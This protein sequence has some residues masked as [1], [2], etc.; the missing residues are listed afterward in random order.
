MKKLLKISFFILGT[1]LILVLLLLAIMQTPWFKDFA[2]KQIE[3]ITNEQLN[4][5]LSIGKIDGN[6]LGSLRVTDIEIRQGNSRFIYCDK[7][8]FDYD[9]TGIISNSIIINSVLIDSLSINIVQL[10]DTL[11]NFNDLIKT[12]KD[13]D[14]SASEKFNWKIDVENFNVLNSN[15]TFTVLDTSTLIPK[16][17]D[18]V[19][20]FAE[21]LIKPESTELKINNLGFITKNPG[22]QLENLFIDAKLTDTELCIPSFIIRTKANEININGRYFLGT[23]Q[24]SYLKLITQPI[25][26]NEFAEFLPSLKLYGNPI[27][28]ISGK[29][30]NNSADID[31]SIV[32]KK[33]KINLISN[34]NNLDILPNYN[35]EIEIIKIDVGYWL[36][37]SSLMTDLNAQLNING[38]GTSIE[39]FNAKADLIVYN[40]ELLGRNL[41]SLKISSLI[42]E[43]YIKNELSIKSEFG[44]LSGIVNLKDFNTAQQFDVKS[45]VNNLNIAPLLLDSSLVSN[46]NFSLSAV[47]N[48]FNTNKMNGNFSFVMDSSKFNNYEI[49]SIEAFITI[50]E[51]VYQI[52]KFNFDNNALALILKGKFSPVKSN[53]ILF[54]IV[55][56]D[57]EKL[58]QLSNL[59]NV[60]IDGG[61]NGQILGKSDSLTAK[62]NY[63]FSN[64]TLSTNSASNFYGEIN[65]I[66][67]SDSI[68][69]NLTSKI[70]N[71]NISETNISEIEMQGEYSNDRIKSGLSIMLDENTFA[72]INSSVKID[73]NINIIIPNLK[74]ALS[75][76]V[77]SNLN[78]SIKI[79]IGDDYY[80]VENFSLSNGNQRLAVSGEIT[81]DSNNL[82]LTIDSLKIAQFLTMFD[83]ENKSSATVNA[84]IKIDGTNELPIANGTITLNDLNYD[85]YFIGDVKTLFFLKDEKLNWDFKLT[86]KG[87]KIISE[88]YIPLIFNIDSSQSIIPGDKQFMANLKIDSLSLK[89]FA[90][91]IEQ[92]DEVEGTV[93]SNLSL[94]NTLNKIEG[95][96]Y[97]LIEDANLISETFGLRYDKVNL[98]IE[99]DSQK[100]F[101]KQIEFVNDDG[102]LNINGVI[103]FA[104]EFMAGNLTQLNLN[105]QANEFEVANSQ[106]YEAK[107]DGKLNFSKEREKAVF[108]GQIDMLRSK[109]YLPYFTDAVSG[110]NFDQNM[111]IL[112]KEL[113]R[114]NIKDTFY[115]STQELEKD[116]LDQPSF[117]KNIDGE[118]TLTIPRNTW[119]TSPEMNIELSGKINV[120]KKQEVIELFGNINTV[121]GEL[122]IYGKEFQV[123]E[124]KIN[125]NGGKEFNPNLNLV[126]KYMFRA[127]DR[128]KK[129]LELKI[130]GTVHNPQLLFLLDGVQID[131]G[132][133]LS[134]ILFGKSLD[135]LTQSE[136]D[137]VSTSEADLAKTIA[138][139]FLAAQLS[140]TVGDALGLDVIEISGNESWQQAS[141]TAGKYLSEDIYASYERGFGSSETNEVNAKIVTLEYQITK[142]LYFQLVEGNDKTSGFDAIIKFSW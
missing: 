96:G 26:F 109:F 17:I 99:A 54:N 29:Y 100:I 106:N 114:N 19:N 1:I 61:I 28:E 39:E 44:R 83:D 127:A 85:N 91:L 64:L 66:K 133:A 136:K 43:N 77:W 125:F 63:G 98:N 80:K 8:S 34:F 70:E 36:D 55:A 130:T 13:I 119:I 122:E 3:S 25:K 65:L 87:S 113:E 37:D 41:D 79:N 110:R 6:I 20:L 11:W 69:A 31:L 50:N 72:N 56:K 108:N 32:D 90:E 94:Y 60:N 105:L 40:S 33:Q 141:L 123:V 137:N 62:I 76:T 18:E 142:F 102:T 101:I 35:A 21:A 16:R 134:Y 67:K 84:S 2:K 51:G 49:D 24:E 89:R 88:G 95:K 81:P 117:I 128:T 116:S 58:P 103:G 140:S 45:S 57:V 132:N 68:S 135:Q 112:I 115:I 5:S 121:R 104:G 42:T 14:S 52:D 23:S 30:K 53:N 138:G 74:L 139:N 73:S 92:V 71:I 126:L 38:K 97:F 9:L 131:E 111:P 129:Y 46:L 10:N 27:L 12:G 47:G 86:N 118:L 93:K 59:E 7:I 15:I 22:I 82:F 78:D 120:V 4:G 124:G 48:N 75:D 107:I